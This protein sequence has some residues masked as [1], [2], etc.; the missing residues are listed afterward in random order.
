MYFFNLD[1]I[2]HKR[3]KRNFFNNNYGIRALII[4]FCYMLIGMGVFV[5]INNICI[6]LM[7]F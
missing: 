6:E 5:C 7:M 2:M 4:L 3:K 1:L